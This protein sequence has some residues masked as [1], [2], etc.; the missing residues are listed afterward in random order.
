VS[1]SGGGEWRGYLTGNNESSDT[2]SEAQHE[3]EVGQKAAPRHG[4]PPPNSDDQR[5]LRHDEDEV[6][7]DRLMM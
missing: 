5:N 6:E 1:R 3:K 2:N 7:R 4:V